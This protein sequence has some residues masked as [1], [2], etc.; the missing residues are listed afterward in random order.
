M[1]TL[2]TLVVSVLVFGIVIFVHELGHFLAAKRCGIQVNEFSIGMGPAIW[3][4]E[5]N[6]TKYSIR[7]LPIGGYNAMEG[8]DG[9]EENAEELNPRA[10][11]KSLWPA[12]ISGRPFSQATVG[13]RMFVIVSGALMNFVLGFLVIVI[14]VSCQSGAITSKVIYDFDENA[15]CAQTG[16]QKD[17][18]ILSVNGQHCFVASDV[19]YELQRTENYAAAFKVLRQ[20]KIVTLPDVQFDQVVAEDGSKTMSLG[21]RVYGIAKTPH[22]VFKESLNEF[23]YYARLIVRS[24]VDL[25]RGRVSVNDLSGPVGIVSAI[26]TAV[27]YGW[28]DVLSLAALIT[29][30]LGIFNLLPLPALD[31]GRFVFLVIEGVRRKPVPLK[32]QA[33]V[34]AAG[35]AVLLMLMVFV[36]FHDITRFF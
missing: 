19:V 29:I 25:V 11:S 28:A 4:K 3:Q 34:N 7:L 31:G 23:A 10:V 27:S 8:E 14:L 32:I 12:T 24:L 9:T 6:G 33:A 17:D 22:S 16:L 35:M 1:S 20:G 5:K 18:E 13:Q 26:N 2:I 30:N 15:L 36:T 21:F